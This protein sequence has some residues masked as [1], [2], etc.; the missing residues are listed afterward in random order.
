MTGTGSESSARNMDAASR[1]SARFSSR[2][3]PAMR[4]IH[5]RS[6]P[7]QNDDPAPRSTTTR[8]DPSVGT[9]AAHDDKSRMRSSLKALRTSGRLSVTV[10]TAPPDTDS[11]VITLFS[12]TPL[13]PE[14]AEP[15]VAHGRVA[16][17][18]QAERERIASQRRIEHAVVPQARGGVVR[19]SFVVILLKDWCF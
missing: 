18:R 15:R 5:C 11:V 6:A 4:D 17:R 7:A 13:H 12:A 19:R 16:R 8:I 3:Y 1:A 9:V 10:V 14:D 2:V